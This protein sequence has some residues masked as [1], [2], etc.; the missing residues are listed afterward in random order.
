MRTIYFIFL[1]CYF[2]TPFLPT[3]GAVDKI[4]FQWLYLAI[5]NTLFFTYYSLYLKRLITFKLNYS[6]ISFLLFLLFSFLSFFVSFNIS[7]YFIESSRLITLLFTLV[8][9]LQ[10]IN[11]LDLTYLDFKKYVTYFLLIEC[12]FFFSILFIDFYFFDIIN[13]RGISSNI[14]IQAFSIV[15]KLPFVLF[16]SRSN[17]SIKWASIISVFLSI[18]ILFLI[19]SRA[20]LLSLFFIFLFFIIFYSKKI[21]Y[22][23]FTFFKYTLP[24]FLFTII[25]LN[26][27]FDSGAK[28]SGLTIINTSS[29][30]RLSFY[31]EALTSIFTNLFTGVGLGNWKLFSIEA[32][33][34]LMS[35]YTVPYHAHNDF[36]QI[37]AESGFFAFIF[38]FSFFIFCFLMLRR[39]FFKDHFNEFGILLSITLFLYLIDANLNFPISRPIIQI[40]LMFLISII[41]FYYSSS[42]SYIIKIPKQFFILFF[43]FSSLTS[44]SAYKVFDSFRIQQYLLTDL[45]NQKFDTPIDIVN[46]ID[47]NYPNITATGF[48]IKAI[49]A[50]YF[51][52]DSIVDNLLNNS[53]KDNPFIKYPQALKSI[54]FRSNQI[55]DSSLY[56]AKDAFM[57]LP[58]N[59]LHI[60]NYLAI[61][62]VL[63]DS[64]TIDSLY[65]NVKSMNSNN[66]WNAYLL[67]H[68]FLDREKS[69]SVDKFFNEALAKYPD[70]DRFALYNLR[71]TNGD[72]IIRVANELFNTADELFIKGSYLKSAENYLKASKLLP[73]DPAYLENAAH[74]YY[75][76]NYN[77]KAL[78]L[79][80]SVINHYDSRSGK[81]HYL[82]GLMIFETKNN[83]I[84]ACNLFNIA[85]KKG[86]NDAL[87][88]QKLICR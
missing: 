49:K 31:Q 58:N 56:Y 13:F 17:S 57:G 88:A 40:Q 20:S 55:L 65:N 30:Q 25:L 41:Y 21:F 33:S 2:I 53:I 10:L 51:S 72:S 9:F 77:S 71:F 15:F 38:Y 36:L 46:S 79:F 66:V 4:G 70:D 42:T 12:L 27:I 68:L 69:T 50:N 19:S 64:L 44:F 8:A 62:T 32:H 35:S 80:D 47:V 84:D 11:L 86:N 52:S 74:G 37:A 45:N 1:F 75:M 6:F 54:R 76:A 85:I 7:E 22:N 14:N 61:L 28:L 73:E 3:F 82:K 81:A 67:S 60:V 59:E 78:K 87:K 43:I 34:K 24:G 83:A 63:S 5:L 29:L 26:P 18:S 48:P 16:V 23:I 39:S